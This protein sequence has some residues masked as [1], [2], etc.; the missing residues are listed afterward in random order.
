MVY[1]QVLGK[2]PLATILRH[3]LMA[4]CWHSCGLR[5]CHMPPLS[6]PPEHD[7][8]VEYPTIAEF[9]GKLNNRYP[10][11]ALAAY[12][13][14]F[15]LLDYYHIDELARMHIEDLMGLEFNMTSGNARFLLGEA[16]V[17]VKQVEWVTK[18]AHTE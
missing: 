2:V 5:C 4:H 17:V 18:R 14:N 15:E 11:R 3:L 6:D 16:T 12:H 10:Q 8:K 1:P 9:L 7:D 13:R